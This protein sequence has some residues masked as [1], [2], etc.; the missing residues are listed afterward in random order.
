MRTRRLR[1]LGMG[2]LLAVSAGCAQQ[3]G[4]VGVADI[5]AAP[6]RFW[7]RVVVLEGQVTEVQSNPV[8]TTRGIYVL[9]DE[10]SEAGLRVR[11]SDLPASSTEWK[12]RSSRTRTTQ[13]SRSCRRH[14]GA[15]WGHGGCWG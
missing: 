3:T 10:S 8:G 1:M 13:R 6:Q 2:A 4:L 9:I 12:A 15:G 7:N 11:S 5:L 14:G